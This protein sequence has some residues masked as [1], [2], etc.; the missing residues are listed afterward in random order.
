M[1]VMKQAAD[2]QKKISGLQEELGKRTVEFSSGGGK[3]TVTARGDMTV[4]KIRIDP[5]VVDPQDVEMLE[6]LVLA[7]VDGALK[8]ARDL[9]SREMAKA[10][11]GLP[12]PPGMKMPF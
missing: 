12:L 10:T 4:E 3:V 2:M 11:E 1:K 5:A 7:A 8:E 9:M 6:D